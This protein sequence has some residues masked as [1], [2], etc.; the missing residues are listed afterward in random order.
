MYC[1]QAKYNGGYIKES[2]YFIILSMGS[3]IVL[4]FSSYV[5]VEGSGCFIVFH[6]LLYLI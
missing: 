5:S 4:D 1:G 6:K 3:F 2:G